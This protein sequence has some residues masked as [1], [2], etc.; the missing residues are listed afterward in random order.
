MGHSILNFFLLVLRRDF[1]P[2][3]FALPVF[4]SACMFLNSTDSA[5]SVQ[6]HGLSVKWGLDLG[7]FMGNSFIA[8][9]VGFGSLRNAHFSFKNWQDKDVLRWGFMIGACT[10]KVHGE[11]DLNFVS[12]FMGLRL[13]LSERTFANSLLAC[14]TLAIL[15]H[16]NCEAILFFLALKGSNQQSLEAVIAISKFLGTPDEVFIKLGNV[17]SYAIAVLPLAKGILVKHNKPHFL[18]DF[19][20]S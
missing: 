15:E 18:E 4:N 9:C 17:W 1:R 19:W 20:E 5:L 2:Y 16:V 7:D 13:T 14:T 11:K 6:V 12:N 3:D 10:I 8:L